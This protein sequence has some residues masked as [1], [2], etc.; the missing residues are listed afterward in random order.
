LAFV[1]CKE[2]PKPITEADKE[3][4]RES[5][6]KA[7]RDVRIAEMHLKETDKPGEAILLSEKL[8]DARAKAI[9][10]KDY[11]VNGGYLTIEEADEEMGY[12]GEEIEGLILKD[13]EKWRQFGKK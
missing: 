11:Y 8:G 10:E 4:A 12:A 5:I 9:N 6:Q 7:G 1:S 3:I 2:S 13:R